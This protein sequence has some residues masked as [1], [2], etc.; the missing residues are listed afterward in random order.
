[1]KTTLDLPDALVREI[2]LRAVQQG[3]K[4]KD[5]VADLLRKG[6]AASDGAQPVRRKASGRLQKD[7]ATGLPLIVCDPNA[8]AG[9]MTMK[10]LL[11]LEQE[12][13]SQ[14]DLERLGLSV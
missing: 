9:K 14:E 10:Q 5:A 8:P 2:K 13:Q 4:L 1:M 12:S 3:L 7:P 6:L 11:A